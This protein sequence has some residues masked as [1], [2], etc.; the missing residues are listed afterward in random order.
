MQTQHI[1]I[2]YHNN[3]VKVKLLHIQCHV[4]EFTKD[5]AKRTLQ[6]IK[7]SLCR[8]VYLSRYVH[9]P[10]PREECPLSDDQHMQVLVGNLALIG[11]DLPLIALISITGRRRKIIT[12]TDKIQQGQSLSD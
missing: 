10:H 1:S 4:L 2:Q 3:E 11:L 8:S 12:Y 5:E 7:Q 9:S 6:K